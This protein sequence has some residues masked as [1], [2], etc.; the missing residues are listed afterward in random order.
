M[1]FD[2]SSCVTI[3]LSKGSRLVTQT[4]NKIGYNLF[5][6]IASAMTITLISLYTLNVIT[7]KENKRFTFTIASILILLYAFLYILLMLTDFSLLIGSIGTFII[8]ALIMYTT[9]NIE[10][11]KEE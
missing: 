8:I 10:W 5:Y 4:T 9:R 7:R 11:Y 3:S 1:L 2:K 6:L